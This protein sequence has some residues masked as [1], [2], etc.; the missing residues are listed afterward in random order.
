MMMVIAFVAMTFDCE[1]AKLQSWAKGAV[2]DD[3]GDLGEV[4]DI[5]LDPQLFTVVGLAASS[6]EG[7]HAKVAPAQQVAGH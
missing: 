6:G 7:D 1:G 5:A 2:D 4:V 3:V